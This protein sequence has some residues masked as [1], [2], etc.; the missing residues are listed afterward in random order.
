EGTRYGIKEDS[1]DGLLRSGEPG[2]QLT[3]MDAKVGDWIV[4][5]RTGKAVEINALWYNALRSMAGFA[6]RLRQPSKPWDEL[7]ARVKAGF[8]RFWNSDRKIPST[9]SS[10][11][12]SPASS[13]P[14]WTPRLV[15]G[16][17]RHGLA[18]PS[19]ST[20]SGT[21]RSA[22]WPASQSG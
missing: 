3:W 14:G 1:I 6:K 12:A 20:R 7:A 19:R 8:D 10:D 4:T 13:S 15:T 21:T 9:A 16:S 5:P 18:R 22:R 11:R 17:S 2:V